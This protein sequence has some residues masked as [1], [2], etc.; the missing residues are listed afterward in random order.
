MDAVTK[1]FTVRSFV[2]LS[3]YGPMSRG[4]SPP[5]IRYDIGDG[6]STYL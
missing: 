5:G 4:C 2:F 3:G 6:R 1:T